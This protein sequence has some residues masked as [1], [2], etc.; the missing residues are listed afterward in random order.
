MRLPIVLL[1]LPF[2]AARFEPHEGPSKPTARRQQMPMMVSDELDYTPQVNAGH[3]LA[4]LLTIESSTSIFYSYA[5]ELE[6][7]R[8]LSDESAKLTLLAPTNKAVMALARKPHQGSEV[9]DGTVISEE[10]FDKISKRNVE[11]WVSA[12]II[13]KT[14][15]TLEPRSYSTLLE[16]KSVVFSTS[17]KSTDIVLEDGIH[18]SEMKQA[19]NGAIYV[20]DG[21]VN[22]D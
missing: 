19:S 14:L 20:I 13:P 12:H 2:A 15:T 18:I 22:V 1:L 21:T 8:L 6:L 10:E 7:S 3:T 11:K 5:R 9:E 17:P 16:G 4:D